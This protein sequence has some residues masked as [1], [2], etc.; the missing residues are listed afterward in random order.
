MEQWDDLVVPDDLVYFRQGGLRLVTNPGL[1]SWCLLGEAEAAVLTALARRAP[2]ADCRTASVE[3]TLAR[4][5]LNWIVYLPGHVPSVRA[6][7]PRLTTV[8]Y[9]V[10]DGCNLR[11]PYCYASS[12]KCLPGELTT[13]E[14]MDL[15]DQIAGMGV[16][17]LIFTGGEPMLRKDLFDLVEHARDRGLR[18]NII[19]NATMIRT[20]QIARRFA[21]LFTTVTVSIDGGTA[22]VHERT[23]GK[24]TFAKTANAL[25]LLNQAGVAPMINHVVTPENVDALE[26]V[27][28]FVDDLRIERVRLINHSDLGRGVTDGYDFGWSDFMRIQEFCWTNPKAGKL[29]PE[30]PKATKPCSLKGNC[31]MGGNEIYVDSLGDVYPCKLVTKQIHR[32]GNVRHKPLAELFA[33]PVLADMRTSTVFSGDRLADCRKCYIRGACGGGCRAYHMAETGDINRNGRHLCRILRHSMVSS[34][35]LANGASGADLARD[36]DEMLR[37]YLIKDDSVHPVYEDWKSA[38]RRLLPLTVA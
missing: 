25:R 6:P 17:Y 23:R 33:A 27:A 16:S 38:G 35:W 22:E 24:G 3:R 7:E 8:Y 18:V 2:L 30:G 20:P 14:S 37:P 11:C 10:T 21:D 32:A 4:L 34:L 13:A 1:A 19:T 29:L 28:E 5:V 26:K 36:Q 9:A 31:G 15:I 12:E